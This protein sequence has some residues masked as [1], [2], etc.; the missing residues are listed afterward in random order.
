[1]RLV[2][3][4]A[5]VCV[6]VLACSYEPGTLIVRDDGGLPTS[7]D[8]D[9]STDRSDGSVNANT[10]TAIRSVAIYRF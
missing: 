6:G 3:A 8:A 9:A 2:G 10:T 1:M 4:L 7:S 5:V